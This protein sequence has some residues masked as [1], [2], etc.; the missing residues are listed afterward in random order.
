[1]ADRNSSSRP[2]SS[3]WGNLSKTLA[4][5]AL[6]AVIVIALFQLMP[7]H[8]PAVFT[9]TDFSR[10]LEGG[11]VKAVEVIDGKSLRGEFR[12]AVSHDGQQV[13]VFTTLL[14]VSNSMEVVERLEAAGVTIDA[15]ESKNGFA[16]FLVDGPAVDR[17]HRALVVPLPADAG[18]REPRLRVREVEG[19]AAHRR[20]AQDHLRRR[21]RCRR[22]EGRAA[23]GH[24]VPQGSAEV[25]PARRPAARRARCWWARRAPARPCSPRRSRARRAGR[26]SRCRGPTSW[27]CSSASAPRGSATCSNRARPTRHASSSSTRSMP[28]DA[29]VAPDSVAAM[30]SASRRSTS[31][32]SRWTASSRTTA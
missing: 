16:A 3:G 4:L 12:T 19:Q 10:Q 32:W 20:H 2:P 22:G 29:I 6:G 11:N 17:D 13:T 31:C 8:S 24:R 14:P 1:M 9:Y 21:G 26:S 23:G 30:T 28:W 15:K 27:R 7:K 5:W 25:H 18:R